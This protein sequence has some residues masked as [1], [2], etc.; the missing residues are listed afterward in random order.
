[1]LKKLRIGPKLLLA[2]GLV[3]A[4]L[5]LLSAA[6]YYGMVRQNATLENMVQVR[7]ARLKAAADVAGDVN[8]AHA[9]IYQLLAWIN[10]SFA[11]NRLDALIADI[12]SKHA[13]IASALT[14]LA[15]VAD[16][17]EKAIIDTSLAALALYRK[18]V[19]ETI[20][21]AQVDQS[22]ATNAMAKAEKQ[23]NIL[24]AELARLAALE[25]S[26]SDRA[27]ASARA[28]FG[29]LSIGMPVLVLLS[30]VL[31]LVAT[32]LV[33][34]AMLLD[35]RAISHTVADLADGRLRSGGAS[36]GCDEIAQASRALDQ[37][38]G[39]LQQTMTAIL[40]A[41]QS[42]DTASQEIAC[43]NADL[44]A[45]TELQA[46]SLQETA[47]AMHSLTTAV[48]AN[49]R[50][51]QLASE[52]AG[53]AATL[54]DT[55]GQAV[56]RAV[57]SM[58]SIRASS[59]QIVDIIGVIDA[60]AFQTNIL[61]LNAA[62]EAARAGEH[63]RG[64]AVVA[65]EV[66]ALAQRSATAAREIKALIAASVATIDGGN[67][68]V[69][70]AGASMGDI[71]GA[72]AKVNEIVT[73]ISTASAE[74]ADGIADV[75]RAVGQMDDM[76]QQNA[77]LVEQAAAAAESLH[78]QTLHLAQ[79]VSVFKIEQAPASAA[80]ERRARASPMRLA[81]GQAPTAPAPLVRRA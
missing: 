14:A 38:I 76:T 55:G 7:A 79:A 65:S 45:R 67:A 35:V 53:Q 50:H 68:S 74:Q 77:A 16:P 28:Q 36:D 17:A 56:L 21:L 44:S 43:G 22:I 15:S 29:A 49:A 81:G 66:R 60:I 34:R 23:F 13:A 24:N 19:N 18:G 61:A 73:R 71:V 37:T 20:E 42:I 30:M 78:E 69:S 64:F 9:N 39:K 4:L 46:S 80:P 1:M 63:G 3:L 54:A 33:R 26:M 8:Y 75:N 62:V 41:V 27:Y 32:M 59:R 48:Q 25:K 47:S 40:G 12:G 58:A 5:V 6:A 11:R 51:A 10:G 70:Q 52:L 57:S 2:P 31:S 72:V